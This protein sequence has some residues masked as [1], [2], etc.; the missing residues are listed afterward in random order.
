MF[1]RRHSVRWRLLFMLLA[2]TLAPLS[3]HALDRQGQASVL[4]LL[5]GQPGLPAASLMAKL[6]IAVNDLFT[7]ISPRLA[8]LQNPN[9][10][11]FNAAGYDFLGARVADAVG[12]K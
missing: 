5:P 1:V 10:V 8:E 2:A 11:H 12:G 3:A 7:A 9:D 6:G 4:V